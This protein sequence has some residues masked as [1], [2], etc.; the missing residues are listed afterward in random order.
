MCFTTI[1]ITSIDIIL[2]NELN[3]YSLYSNLPIEQKINRFSITRTFPTEASPAVAVAAAGRWTAER[4]NVSANERGRGSER[5]RGNARG[6]DA[7]EKEGNGMTSSYFIR[8][9]L[10]FNILYFK[11]EIIII[12]E[13]NHLQ[14][15]L[16]ICQSKIT[17]FYFSVIG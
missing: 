17:E 14:I 2:V 9:F 11:H 13:Q 16:F 8:F 7:K 5:G 12:Y 1:G 3:I 10:Q 6:D 15:D 4:E